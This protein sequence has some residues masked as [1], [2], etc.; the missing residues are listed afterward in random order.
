MDSANLK[1]TFCFVDFL[2]LYLSAY[3]LHNCFKIEIK[4][5]VKKTCDNVYVTFEF[6]SFQLTHPTLAPRTHICQNQP[7]TI[8]SPY[9]FSSLFKIS[10]L[11]IYC[12]KNVKI[13]HFVNSV[14]S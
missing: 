8:T 7:R 9:I 6:S 2:S 13:F 1:K 3:I 5:I 4:K 14:F 11:Q 10:H 12:N